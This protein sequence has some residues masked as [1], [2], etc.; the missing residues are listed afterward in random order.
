MNAFVIALAYMRLRP[1]HTTLN[2]LLL[3]LGTAAI[4]LLMLFSDQLENRMIRDAAGIDMVVGAKGSPMQLILSSLYHLDVP[5][6][7]I[8]LEDVEQLKADARVR[9]VMNLA[10]GDSFRG[11]RIVGSS[12]SYVNHYG[13]KVAIGALWERPMD[14]TLGSIVAKALNLRVG[15]KF[16]PSHG[17]SGGGSSH[18]EHTYHI[19]GV[20]KPT[21]KVIDRLILTSV[22]SVWVVHGHEM[23]E[24]SGANIQGEERHGESE[25]TA[26]LV[27]FANPVAIV[28]LPRAINAG[29]SMQAALPGYE[30]SRLLKLVGFGIDGFRAFA[31]VLVISAGL[32]IFATLYN[33]LADR[34]YD[35]AVFRALGASQSRVLWQ[36]LLEGVVLSLMGS[37]LGLFL[38]HLV[39]ELAGKWLW[40]EH[41][42]YFSGLTWLPEESL[43][44][45][46][47][48]LIGILAGLL[49]AIQAY[50]LEVSRI[51]A[52]G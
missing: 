21:G 13:A 29:T 32:G 30:I 26:A 43:L 12:H 11:F 37:V 44:L 20:L 46:A 35:I 48:I 22:E 49:P 23:A 17:F 41:Q 16:I 47:A 45:V 6:G 51:L 34:R 2:V 5:T 4:S 14:V 18:R 1:L 33:A 40:S 7:N 27:K 9:S 28:S 38:G 10:L 8:P 19:V 31:A 15:D 24:G 52:R 39:A 42:I 36:F 25:V 50:R 3:A